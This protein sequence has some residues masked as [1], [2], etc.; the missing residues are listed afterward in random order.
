MT[1]S[2]SPRQGGSFT[3]PL[4]DGFYRGLLFTLTIN[5]WDRSLSYKLLV[6]FLVIPGREL[7]G[8]GWGGAHFEGFRCTYEVITCVIR[9][10]QRTVYFSTPWLCWLLVKCKQGEAHKA[11]LSL[12]SYRQAVFA[13]RGRDLS[14]RDGAGSS[15]CGQHWWNSPSYQNTKQNQT[16]ADVQKERGRL[17]GERG[18]DGEEV[19]RRQCYICEWECHNKAHYYV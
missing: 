10:T 13:G 19:K 4:I 7:L 6:L 15:V 1:H 8:W 11:R 16:K 14:F 9:A 12:R 18:Q 3:L 17:E 5:I 2:I